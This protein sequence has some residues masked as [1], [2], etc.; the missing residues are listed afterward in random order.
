MLRS[1][2][3]LTMIVVGG[4][5]GILLTALIRIWALVERSGCRAASVR[6]TRDGFRRRLVFDCGMSD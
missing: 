1:K 5:T 4:L 2:D 6:M 3:V